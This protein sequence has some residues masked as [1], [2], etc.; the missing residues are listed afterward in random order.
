MRQILW[1]AIVVATGTYICGPLMDPDLWW[2]ITVGRWMLAHHQLP[3]VDLWNRFALNTPWRPYSWSNEIIFAWLDQHFG[4]HGLLSFKILIGVSLAFTLFYVYGRLARDWFFGGLLGMFSTAACYNHFTLRPQSIVWIFLALLLNELDRVEQQGLTRKRAC[5]LILITALWANTHITAGLTLLVAG[6]F[7]F[8]PW[9]WKL[10]LQALGCCFLG[11]LITPHFGGEWLTFFNTSSHPFQHSSIAEFHPATIMQHSTAFLVIVGALLLLFWH[12]VPQA[13]DPSKLLLAAAFALIGL[14]VVK[15]LPFAVIIMSSLCALYWRKESSDFS[16][17][18][19]IAD[20][21]SRLGDLYA[22]VPQEGLAFVFI[23]MA[24]V[25]I[26]P[27]WRQPISK[28]IVPVEAVDF[29][30]NHNLPHPIM[31]D[32]GRGGYIMYRYSN[33]RGELEHPVPIDG[34]TNVNSP[35][36]WETSRQALLGQENWKSYFD[37]VKPNTVLWPRESPLTIIL[38]ESPEWCRVYKNGSQ[39]NGFSVFVKSALRSPD[40]SSDDCGTEVPPSQT[41]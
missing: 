5:N 3:S 4:A 10:A 30:Q 35:E 36:A 26:V 14:A 13:L 9:R 25:N 7:L 40:L 29:M 20:G 37:L 11:T 38:L 1:L 23:C 18:G 22:R 31:N 21:I 33:Q 8:W 17:F 27:L 15:F 16:V 12:R 32:F 6:M 34:R 2:H 28:E 39:T 41:N 24:V 19:N